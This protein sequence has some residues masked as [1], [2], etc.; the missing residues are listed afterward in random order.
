MKDKLQ[1]VMLGGYAGDGWISIGRYQREL[2]RGLEALSQIEEPIALTA[3]APRPPSWVDRLSS[4][5]PAGARV[6]SYWSRFVVYPRQIPHSPGAVYHLVDQSLSYL[7]NYLDPA[8]TVITCHDLL[9]FPL[10]DRRRQ[11]SPWPWVSDRLY[12][13]CVRKLPACAAIIAVSQRNKED[14]IRYLG[15]DPRRIK[16]IYEG[17][18]PA[19]SNPPDPGQL[20]SLRAQLKLPAGPLLLH[21]GVPT[22]Y[23]NIDGLLLALAELRRRL[24]EP[25][26]L[27]RVGPGLTP[28]QRRLAGR[29]G[30][31]EAV[32]EVGVHGDDTL[33]ALNHLADCLVFPSLYEGF[34][35]PPLEAMACGLPVVA[36]NRGSLP[37]ILRGAALLVDP[38][39]PGAIAQAVQRVLEDADL[40]QELRRRGFEHSRG[41]RWERAAEQTLAVYRSVL[42]HAQERR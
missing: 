42:E 2:S 16:V 24:R 18:S 5:G 13:F 39:D 29:L 9:H 21:V 40:R 30:L 15:C 22:F 34:G 25:V 1:V 4:S 41:F 8:R 37:E 35:F 3:V 38:E 23:K 28:V 12:R 36:S 33:P 31:T 32:R 27:L 7:V 19:F 17:V 11:G 14:A 10:W 20:A 26:T 6:A